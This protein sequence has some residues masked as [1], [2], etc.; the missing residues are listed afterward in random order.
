MLIWKAEM[1]ERCVRGRREIR[2]VR[3]KRERKQGFV[4]RD[5]VG[6]CIVM[7]VEMCGRVESVDP[8]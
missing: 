2:R 6:R 7:G 1:W 8:R 4:Q 5:L 3:R